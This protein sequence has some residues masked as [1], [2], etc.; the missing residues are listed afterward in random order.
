[1]TTIRDYMDK[2]DLV[3]NNLVNEQK[4]VVMRNKQKIITLNKMQ[5][6]DGFGSDDRVL[7]NQ[8]P[9]FSGKYRTGDKRGQKYD[10]F[11]TGVFYR[12]LNI[13]FDGNESFDIFSTGI[14]TTPD[15]YDFFK[16]YFNLFGLDTE[17]RRI[18][19]YEIIKPELIT[20]IKKY[21]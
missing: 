17:S 18:L 11:E 4:K 1:M 7:K 9:V 10:F 21:L 13:K 5:F 8:N 19:N 15:K 6:I 16:G 12:G 20:Y 14:D 3:I 2:C